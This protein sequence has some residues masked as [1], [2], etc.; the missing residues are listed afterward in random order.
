MENRER[1]LGYVVYHG[2][3]PGDYTAEDLAGDAGVELHPPDHPGWEY[4]APCPDGGQHLLIPAAGPRAVFQEN[5]WP[6]METYEEDRDDG[7]DLSRLQQSH[8][9][10]G[11]AHS[12]S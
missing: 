6:V 3:A 11:L 5:Y 9:P 1:V 4:Y 7:T 12:H 10:L 8:P 2:Y